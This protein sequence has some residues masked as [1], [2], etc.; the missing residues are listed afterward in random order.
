MKLFVTSFDFLNFLCLC[1]FD[2]GKREEEGRNLV[3]KKNKQ[4][5]EVGMYKN[6]TFSVTKSGLKCIVK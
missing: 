6:M 2:L 1:L 4:R 3:W 5:K